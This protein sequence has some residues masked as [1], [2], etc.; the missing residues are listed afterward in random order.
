MNAKK[1]HSESW[2]SFNNRLAISSYSLVHKW[3]KSLY[4]HYCIADDETWYW[5]ICV[6]HSGWIWLWLCITHRTAFF[7]KMWFI[8]CSRVWGSKCLYLLDLCCIL[9]RAL[10]RSGTNIPECRRLELLDT[11]A[12]YC[13]CSAEDVTDEMIQQ[14]SEV[15]PKYIFSLRK[16]ILH[17]V[18]CQNTDTI[19]YSKSLMLKPRV[20]KNGRLE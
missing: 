12:Q 1:R 14:A 11:V 13:D 9:C 19:V 3:I 17:T 20:H 10:L 16:Y 5:P 8:D 7:S 4:M 2:I 15:N 18:A 6:L